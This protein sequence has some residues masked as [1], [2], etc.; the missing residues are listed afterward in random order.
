MLSLQPSVVF[1]S[2]DHVLGSLV[3]TTG[4]KRKEL[5]SYDNHV[6]LLKLLKRGFKVPR[7]ER[8]SQTRSGLDKILFCTYRIYQLFCP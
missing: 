5:M 1:T 3:S 7:F 8:E 2:L 6:L 4:E